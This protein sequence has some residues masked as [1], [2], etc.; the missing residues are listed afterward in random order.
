VY[1]PAPAVE[2]PP[3]DV[4]TFDA[5]RLTLHQPAVTDVRAASCH[6]LRKALMCIVVLRAYPRLY[7]SPVQHPV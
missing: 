6:P 5:R 2:Q 3:D 1:V 7:Q 4:K